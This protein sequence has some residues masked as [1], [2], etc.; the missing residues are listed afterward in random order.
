MSFLSDLSLHRG[1]PG[2]GGNPHRFVELVGGEEIHYSFYE[3]DP[4]TWRTEY[5]YNTRIN[6]LY[7]KVTAVCPCTGIRS[8]H[9]KA[10]SS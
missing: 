9:W 6:V 3:P 1:S 5:F 7:K 10:I 2:V 8:S 4:E